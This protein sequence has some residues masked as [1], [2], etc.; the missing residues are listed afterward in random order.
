[1]NM[2]F[3]HNFQ[4]SKKDKE[5]GLKL[6]KEMSEELA[7]FLGIHLGDGSM[8]KDYRYTYKVTYTCNSAEV[9]YAQ[10]ITDLFERL[11][12]VRLRIVRD[13]KSH[14]VNLYYYSK[15]LCEFLNTVLGIPY[16][17][18]ID[19]RIPTLVQSDTKYSAAFIRGVFDTDGCFT[20]QKYGKY[21]YPLVKICTKHKRFANEIMEVLGNLGIPAFITR[22]M[23]MRYPAYD[24]VVRNKNVQKFI[25]IVGSHN[26]KNIKK[27]GR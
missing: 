15:T 16:G 9:Q 25:D 6:P 2:K 8:S 19:L 20:T 13:D 10:Y 21:H 11:F 26:I 17:E 12:N 5:K 3:H 23:N 27:W 18:K 22:K 1:M 14:C 24:V 4:L 7:E